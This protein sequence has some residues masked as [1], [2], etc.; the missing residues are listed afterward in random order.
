MW[1][2]HIYRGTTTT[3]TSSLKQPDTTELSSTNRGDQNQESNRYR[4]RR[5]FLQGSQ[6]TT[7]TG[8]NLAPFGNGHQT[9]TIR[10]NRYRMTTKVTSR[11]RTFP[12]PEG[13]HQVHVQTE[14]YLEDLNRDMIRGPDVDAFVQTDPIE[15]EELLSSPL[16]T[17]PPGGLSS[18][19][20]IGF[21]ASKGK[22][23]PVV[24]ASTQVLPGELVSFDERVQPVVEAV[25]GKILEQ[26]GTQFN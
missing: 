10:S 23:L 25:V 18:G 4:R 17:I 14:E 12:P 9:T 11:S 1:D 16:V 21:P 24:D 6:N 15:D 13:R 3:L 26:V 5:A 20:G 8:N 7:S 22:M 2:P 19:D